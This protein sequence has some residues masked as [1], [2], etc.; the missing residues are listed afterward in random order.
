MPN[1]FEIAHARKQAQAQAQA[2]DRTKAMVRALD[3]ID[4]AKP[5][6]RVRLTNQLLGPKAES[7]LAARAE[8]MAKIEAR[9]KP[10][11]VQSLSELPADQQRTALDAKAAKAKADKHRHILSL[12]PKR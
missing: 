10:L 12:L 9:A 1:N 7:D 3:L 6:D 11:I 8:M 2:E 4:Q 5:E